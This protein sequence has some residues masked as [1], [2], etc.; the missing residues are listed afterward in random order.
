[1]FAYAPKC[2]K[3]SIDHAMI[4]VDGIIYPLCQT[5]IHKN[6]GNPIVP[7]QVSIL[8]VTETLRLFDSHKKPMAV[9]E[10]EGYSKKQEKRDTDISL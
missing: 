3:V 6:C 10:C 7:V 8:G 5:C 9:V 4:G 1:V 2:K